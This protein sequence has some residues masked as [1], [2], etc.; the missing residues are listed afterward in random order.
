[1]GM[2]PSQY[3]EAFVEGNLLDCHEHPGCVRRAFNAAIAASH[4]ADHYFAF[5]YRHHPEV[6]GAYSTIGQYEPLTEADLRRLGRLGLAPVQLRDSGSIVV[7]GSSGGFVVC[8]CIHL[9]RQVVGNN[10]G[11]LCFTLLRY[12]SK[13]PGVPRNPVAAADRCKRPLS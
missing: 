9:P 10:L 5:N 2:T 3:F 4:L 13:I 8:R 11:V 12:S 1:M 6:V 7:S